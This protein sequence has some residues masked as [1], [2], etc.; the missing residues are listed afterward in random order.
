M[1]WG[2]DA[3][4]LFDRGLMHSTGRGATIDYVAAHKWFNLAAMR[5]SAEARIMRREVAQEMSPAEIADAQHQ[6]REWIR[7]RMPPCKV[8]GQH[9]PGALDDAACAPTGDACP[10]AGAYP[11]GASSAS[12]RE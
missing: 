10:A 5:G 8:M 6:A 4:A 2:T 9:R 7:R 1:L 11:A 3:E 12:P